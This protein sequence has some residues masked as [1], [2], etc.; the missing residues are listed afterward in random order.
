[1]SKQFEHQS[2]G[3]ERLEFSPLLSLRLTAV[4]YALYALEV[5]RL[6]LAVCLRLC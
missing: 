1:M 4:S 6:L 5:C 2:H 3:D